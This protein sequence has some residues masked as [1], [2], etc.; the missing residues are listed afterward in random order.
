VPVLAPT[1]LIIAVIFAGGA[2]LVVVEKPK[3]VLTHGE[4]LPQ[5]AV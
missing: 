4:A 1:Y 5:P 3:E 2:K